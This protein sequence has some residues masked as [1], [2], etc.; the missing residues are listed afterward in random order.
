MYEIIKVGIPLQT[1]DITDEFLNIVEE[2][3]TS[4]DCIALT[5][6]DYWQGEIDYAPGGNYFLLDNLE[7]KP[8]N[9]ILLLN[10]INTMGVLWGDVRDIPNLVNNLIIILNNE[11]QRL[12]FKKVYI[13]AG[14]SP[15]CG[16]SITLCLSRVRNDLKIVDTKS[17]VEVAYSVSNLTTP[18][19]ETDYVKLC[20]KDGNKYIPD[21]SKINIFICLQKWYEYNNVHVLN[22]FF[23]DIK[24]YYNGDDIFQIVNIKSETCIITTLTITSAEPLIEELYNSHVAV[25]FLVYKKELK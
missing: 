9:D 16:D 13:L 22:S 23:K 1:K 4:K 14:G 24:Q 7:F 11:H 6:V 17:C 18:W 2:I 25:V 12:K 20:I 10:C 21:I 5:T 15:L 19:I 3:K 8:Y